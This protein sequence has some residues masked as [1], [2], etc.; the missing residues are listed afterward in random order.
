M[1]VDPRMHV[2]Y[3][4]PIYDPAADSPEALLRRY[5]PVGEWCR[6]L[7]AAGVERVTVLRRFRRSAACERAGIG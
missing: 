6:G 5:F 1:S 3:L 2:L 7:K 4:C